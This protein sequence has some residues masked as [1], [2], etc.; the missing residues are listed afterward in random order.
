MKKLI[1]LLLL[2]PFFSFAQQINVSDLGKK[3]FREV[4]NAH[5]ISPCEVTGGKVLSYCVQDGSRI[6]YLFVNELLNGIMT[7]TSF[8][9]Q[10][11]AERELEKEISE[12]ESTLGIE[13]FI[14]GGKTM[15]NTLSSPI[16]M[17]YSVDKVNNTYYL[18]CY[19]AKK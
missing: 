16:Y 13:P 18:I 3:N 7:M 14:S 2:A 15:F 10:Y 9:T 11:A 17:S 4:E 12:R 19:I 8:S 6:S 1:F 5:T